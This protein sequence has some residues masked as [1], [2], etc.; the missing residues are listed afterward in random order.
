MEGPMATTKQKAK[1]AKRS[2]TPSRRNVPPKAG[3]TAKGAAVKPAPAE[4]TIEP[5]PAPPVDQ[6]SSK[7]SIVLR[8]LRRA[9]GT[10]IAAVSGATGWQIHS[11]RGFFAGVVKK[12]L[13]LNLISEKVDGE[14]V[15]RID[16]SGR[17][18]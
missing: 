11:V 18:A 7:Q 16:E 4:P 2:L 8:M 12:K 5:P 14:R 3:R 15:Y 17:A 13:K 6:S 10:S 1:P 9:E